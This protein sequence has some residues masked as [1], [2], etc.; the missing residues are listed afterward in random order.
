MGERLE[1]LYRLVPWPEDPRSEEGKRRYVEALS[2]M[3]KLLGHE[4][5][6]QLLE[7]RRKVSVLDVCGGTGIGGVALAR[8]LQEAG[9]EV[10]LTILDLRRNAL[11]VA[12]RWGREELGREVQVV[13]A[14]A[15]RAHEI[16]LRADI[17]LMY[18][19][20]APH[21]DPWDMARLFSSVSEVLNS[22][23]LFVIEETDRRYS[24]FFLQGYARALAESAGEDSLVASFHVGYSVR[25]GTFRR[26]TVKLPSAGRVVVSDFYFWGLA[27]LM[28]LAW[29]FF[30]DVDFLPVRRSYSG[31]ILTC[32]PR[33]RLR[34]SDLSR[35]PRVLRET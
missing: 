4:W 35:D 9:V 17:V 2:Q 24:I 29:L 6:K 27:E 22:D 21:F 7:S 3:R 18:G 20:S 31:F 28:T 14:D 8:A 25:R 1:E 12:F 15:R 26:A 16:G 33:G 34:P 23:G 13:E 10:D 19:L 30:E 32:K 5:L 11:E